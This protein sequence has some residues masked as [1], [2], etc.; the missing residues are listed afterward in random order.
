MIKR[1][2]TVFQG[3]VKVGDF[4]QTLRNLGP[5]R[6]AVMGGVVLGLIGVSN[7][8]TIKPL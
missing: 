5:M 1:F 7:K 2:P 6:L 8:A 3:G 4:I